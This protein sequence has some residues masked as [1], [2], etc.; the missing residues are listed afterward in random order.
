MNKEIIVDADTA[1]ALQHEV[2]KNLRSAVKKQNPDFIKCLQSFMLMPMSKR[3]EIFGIKSTFSWAE[4]QEKIQNFYNKVYE[5]LGL[6][7]Q[8]IDWNLVTLPEYSEEFA[9]LDYGQTMDTSVQKTFWR[10]KCV[11]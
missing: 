9:T 5:I 6:P 4:Q 10:Q 7:A 3:K 8:E 11:Q 1:F 2:N